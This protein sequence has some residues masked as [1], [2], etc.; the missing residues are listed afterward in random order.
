MM[1]TMDTS[2]PPEILNG[3]ESNRQ[4]PSWLGKI[5]QEAIQNFNSHRFPTKKDEAWKYIDVPESIVNWP[6]V[7]SQSVFKET[8]TALIASK[9]GQIDS[10]EYLVFL[11]GEFLPELSKYIE[12]GVYSLSTEI[13]DLFSDMVH[14]VENEDIYEAINTIRFADGALVNVSE[15]SSKELDII[16]INIPATKETS[17]HPRNCFKLGSNST[18]TLRI[19][20]ISGNDS[21]FFINEVCCFELEKKST[22]NLSIFANESNATTRFSKLFFKCHESSNLQIA[23][24]NVGTGISRVELDIDFAEPH[25]KATILGL[26]ILNE[27]QTVHQLANVNHFVGDCQCEQIVKSILSD[28][29]CSDYFSTV[30]VSAGAQLTVSNQLNQTLMLS[31]NAESYSRPQLNIDADDVKCAHGATVGQLDEGE[32]FYLKTRG[33]SETKGKQLLIKGFSQEIIDRVTDPRTRK[34]WR[35]FLEKKLEG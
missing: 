15:Y 16:W 12:N 18:L 32:L 22:L 7:E 24:L 10:D 33:I 34:L 31:D 25:A 14:S 20:C 6:V 4:F 27:N 13:P 5:R 30:N 11:N 19:H 8:L 26:N 35:L 2:L 9:I 17:T 21:A 3:T 1:A 29:S 28:S 23:N